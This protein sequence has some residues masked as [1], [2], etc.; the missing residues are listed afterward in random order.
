M[1]ILVHLSL[2][3]SCLWIQDYRIHSSLSGS[4]PVYHEV[5]FQLNA[6][7]NHSDDINPANLVA[8]RIRLSYVVRTSPRVYAQYYQGDG[9]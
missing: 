1:L 8:I 9:T 2:E 4:L 6:F 7:C 5:R 3:S